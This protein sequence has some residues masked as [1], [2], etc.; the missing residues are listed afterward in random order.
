MSTETAAAVWL[1]AY[2][3]KNNLKWLSKVK[4]STHQFDTQQ[5]AP[6]LWSVV[7]QLMV[8]WD[9]GLIGRKLALNKAQIH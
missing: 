7:V 3:D 9:C 5:V 6:T 4:H 2:M 1:T 8:F